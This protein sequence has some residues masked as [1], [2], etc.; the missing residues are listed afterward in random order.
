MDRLTKEQLEYMNG[1]MPANIHDIFATGGGI[2]IKPS[3]EGR[4]TE[5]KKRT[6]K[7]TEEALHSPDPHVRQMAN[8]ARNASHW[9]HA[10]GGAAGGDQQ[11]QIMAV[12]QAYAKA[13][14]VDPKALIQ[15]LQKLDPDQQKAQL[16]VM[17]KAVSGN[18][19]Q[20]GGA[21]PEELTGQGQPQPGGPEPNGVQEYPEGQEPQGGQQDPQQLIQAIQQELEQGAKPEE[22]IAELLQ[23][24]VDP[25]MIVQI[26]VQLGMP[27]QEVIQDIQ[28]LMQQG[29]PEGQPMGDPNAQQQMAPQ[30][31]ENPQE[32]MQEQGQEEPQGPP[33]AYGGTPQFPFGGNFKIHTDYRAPGVIDNNNFNSKLLG[34]NALADPSQ[35]VLPYVSAMS[36]NP[37]TSFLGAVGGGLSAAAGSYLGY[38]SLFRNNKKLQG[39]QNYFANKDAQAQNIKTPDFNG[40]PPASTPRANE[41][42]YPNKQNDIWNQFQ[43]QKDPYANWKPGMQTPDVPVAPMAPMSQVGPQDMY[44]PAAPTSGASMNKLNGAPSMQTLGAKGFYAEGGDTDPGKKSTMTSQE[45]ARFAQIKSNNDVNSFKKKDFDIKQV[46]ANTIANNTTRQK[47]VISTATSYNT[48]RNNNALERQVDKYN[49][50]DLYNREHPKVVV[51]AESPDTKK[52]DISDYSLRNGANFPSELKQLAEQY[53]ETDKKLNNVYATDKTYNDLNRKTQDSYEAYFNT[54]H[55]YKNTNTESNPIVLKARDNYD[56]ALENSDKYANSNTFR[57]KINNLQKA[58]YKIFEKFDNHRLN[59][60]V[61]DST[62]I[63]EG[64]NVKK[65][66]NRTNPNVNVDVVPMYNKPGLMEDKLKNLSEYDKA[67][68]FGHHGDRLAGIPNGDIADYLSKSKVKNCYFGSCYFEDQIKSPDNHFN[69][70]KGKTINYRPVGVYWNGFNPNAKTFDE[71]MWSRNSIG[72]IVDPSDPNTNEQYNNLRQRSDNNNV[73]ISPIKYGRTHLKT[74]YEYGGLPHAQVGGISAGFNF[75]DPYGLNNNA[76][77]QTANYADTQGYASSKAAAARMAQQD[78]YDPNKPISGASTNRLSGNAPSITTQPTPPTT[79]ENHVDQSFPISDADVANEDNQG[80][81]FPSYMSKKN[82]NS[83]NTLNR[84]ISMSGPQIANNAI[85]GLGMVDNWLSGIES[86]RARQEYED[87]KAYNFGQGKMMNDVQNS[88]NPNGDYT[89]N[90]GK[91]KASMYVPQQDFGTSQYA[92]Y[93]GATGYAN[94]GS[95]Q[96]QQGGEYHVTHD[97]LLQLMRNGAEVE[98]L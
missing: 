44:N 7:T 36:S 46:N 45:R 86:K 68:V 90:S 82:P 87:R 64:E 58:S 35:S 77:G 65:F 61:T 28:G 19:M 20:D 32:Q 10:E 50:E 76:F 23:Q 11:E 34:L 33:M 51:F 39:Y 22:V 74:T 21:A 53:D 85:N 16:S 78:I 95:T 25:Q 24:Q 1:Y 60:T 43:K 27:E 62:F 94:G 13:K 59:P 30:E 9:K 55:K 12:I 41:G 40:N 97:E 63:K 80:Y 91:L 54:L 48:A 66:Y 83:V 15:E 69:K 26:F 93:G 42:V 3:H 31:Q 52:Y 14:G 75:S 56:K 73:V 18:Q 84:T 89:V 88:R 38:K 71:G 98:F 67:L 37:V 81:K 79:Y 4:F 49:D 29:A 92:R 57:N 2:H 72:N 47:D 6:G 5:Y 8:F 96:Y 17:Y 70:L